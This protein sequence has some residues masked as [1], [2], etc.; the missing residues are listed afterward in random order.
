MA[1]HEKRSCAVRHGVFS[2]RLHGV[3]GPH[4]TGEGL[5]QF[6]EHEEEEEQRFITSRSVFNKVIGRATT[7]KR[8]LLTIK[9]AYED[10][11]SELKR[12]EDEDKKAQRTVASLTSLPKSLVTC[13]RLAE[14]LRVRI[15]HL[16]SETSNLLEE[17]RRQKS[18]E[19]QRTWIPGLTVAES[20]DPEALDEHLRR[21]EAQ[22]AALLDRKSHCVSLEVK[23]QLHV[24]LQSVEFHREELST[25]NH[26]LKILYKRLRCVCDQLSRWEEE[27]EKQVPLEELLGSTLENIRQTSVTNDDDDDE[28]LFETEE[29]TGVNGSELVA[30]HLDRFIELFDS[31]QYEDAALVAA[32]SPQGV[33][34]NVDTMEMFKGVTA[35]QGSVPPLLLFFQALLITSPPGT[36]LSAPLSLHCVL[37]ALR[38]GA[39]QLVTHA[40]TQNKLTL[41]ERLGDILIQHALEDASVAD[42]CLALATVVYEACGLNRKTALS[43]C[44]R[45]LIHSAAK[46]MHHFKDLTAED[47]IWVLCRSPSLTL[48]HL[49]TEPQ[50][51]VQAAILSVGRACSSLLVDPH[52]GELALQLLDSFISREVLE[53][54]ILEDSDSSV[55]VWINVASLCSELKRPDLNRAIM[56]VLLDQSGTG[57]LSPDLEGARLMEHVFL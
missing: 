57:V 37:F 11:I 10:F 20:E 42:L 7:Y 43:M 17:Q 19:G 1:E 6:E 14:Q 8:L 47:F 5:V 34:R 21:L 54:V 56:S 46:F 48:L 31:A 50:H 44:R 35:A 2:P 36:Q 53:T 33:L 24:E 32:R 51:S 23:A 3:G 16:Q 13:Q 25:E 26:Q 38:H 55:D 45:G 27:E 18:S 49:L 12:R 15:S 4:N 9:T 29:P 52:H 28:E 22:R 30:D 41:S 40:I 39:S